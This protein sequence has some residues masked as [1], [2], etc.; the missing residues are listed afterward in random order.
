MLFGSYLV[1]FEALALHRLFG[2]NTK[3]LILPHLVPQRTPRRHKTLVRLSVHGGIKVLVWEYM[4]L[5]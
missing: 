5:V 2:I 3:M 4:H 1:I